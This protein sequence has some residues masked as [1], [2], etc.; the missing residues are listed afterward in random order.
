MACTK[1]VLSVSRQKG[2]DKSLSAG[3]LR[4]PSLFYTCAM[5]AV[6]WTLMEISRVLKVKS[7]LREK[8]KQMFV[9]VYNKALDN[10]TNCLV[11]ISDSE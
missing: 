10:I 5:Y 9:L 2:R 3:S 1:E 7:V 8:T 4:E 6:Q 11:F